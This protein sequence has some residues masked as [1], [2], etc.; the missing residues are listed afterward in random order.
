MSSSADMGI[1]RYTISWMRT[2]GTKWWL[3]NDCRLHYYYV[4]HTRNSWYDSEPR[5]DFVLHND[6]DLSTNSCVALLRPDDLLSHNQSNKKENE[7]TSDGSSESFVTKYCVRCWQLS[8][9]R[10]HVAL[11]SQEDLAYHMKGKWVVDRSI[12]DLWFSLIVR[13]APERSIRRRCCTLWSIAFLIINPWPCLHEFEFLSSIYYIEHPLL[14][15]QSLVGQA[16]YLIQVTMCLMTEK[17]G[18][19]EHLVLIHLLI[20]LYAALTSHG[21]SLNK[22]KR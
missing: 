20:P 22:W 3:R 1:L 11:R 17:G 6:H 15:R 12:D 13:Q 19:S 2:N 8:H 14:T 7:A 18:W 4:L 21:S 9:R 16:R 5:P 10:M